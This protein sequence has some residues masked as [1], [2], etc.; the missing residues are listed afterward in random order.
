MHPFQQAWNDEVWLECGQ[1]VEYISF[2]LVTMVV[3]HVKSDGDQRLDKIRHVIVRQPVLW[4]CLGRPLSVVPL[5]VY[6]A[7]KE[8]A[9]ERHKQVD[10][11]RRPRHVGRMEVGF[12]GLQHFAQMLLDGAIGLRSG[13]FHGGDDPAGR[14]VQTSCTVVHPE[15]DFQVRS[16][17]RHRQAERNHEPCEERLDTTRP[18]NLAH[19]MQSQSRHQHK[20]VHLENKGAL[21]VGLIFA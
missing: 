2:V 9:K 7:G 18:V 15:A 17:V 20:H 1:A 8:G 11:V 16:C 12:D 5:Q 14:S 6:P 19:M 3:Q 13:P 10:S 4:R 21:R